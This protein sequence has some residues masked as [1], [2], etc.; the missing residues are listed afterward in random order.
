MKGVRVGG[1]EQ[2]EGRWGMK[3]MYDKCQCLISSSSSS[4]TQA[5]THIKN[6][7]EEETARQLA[8]RK[9]QMVHQSVD[10]HA[11]QIP[12]FSLFFL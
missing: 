9:G 5:H 3:I 12:L 6:S 11:K 4:S 8:R 2:E 1:Q 7:R 10:E